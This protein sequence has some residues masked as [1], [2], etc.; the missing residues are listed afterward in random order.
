MKSSSNILDEIF[1]AQSGE[2]PAVTDTTK[3]FKSSKDVLDDIFSKSA[4]PV[5][6]TVAPKVEEPQFKQPGPV[7]AFG[8]DSIYA[9]PGEGGAEEH[10]LYVPSEEKTYGPISPFG[11]DSIYAMPDEGGSEMPGLH[12]DRIVPIEHEETPGEMRRERIRGVQKKIRSTAATVHPDTLVKMDDVSNILGDSL[13]KFEKVEKQLEVYIDKAQGVTSESKGFKEFTK[14][15]KS[16]IEDYDNKAV[17]H[18]LILGEL[19]DL[20][21]GLS[22]DMK[23]YGELVGELREEY[24][25]GFE[26]STADKQGFMKRL[27]NRAGLMI[28]GKEVRAAESVKQMVIADSLGVNPGEL[29]KSWGQ[30]IKSG[31]YDSLAGKITRYH[32]GRF[33]EKIPEDIMAE[34]STP[35]KLGA[36][37]SD[38]GV[39]LPYMAVGG[40]IASAGAPAEAAALALAGAF[41]MP[42]GLRALY[43]YLEEHGDVQDLNEFMEAAKASVWGTVKG[44]GVGLATYGAARAGAP[45]GKIPG[46]FTEVGGMVTSQAFVE[47]R[48]PTQDDFVQGILVISL[49]KLGMSPLKT[50]AEVINGSKNL[51]T[52]FV[53]TGIGPE[54]IHKAVADNMI[55]LVTKEIFKKKPSEASIA[56]AGKLAADMEQTQIKL[57]AARQEKIDAKKLIKAELAEKG[58]KV[59]AAKVEEPTLSPYEEGWKKPE[60]D[61]R[62]QEGSDG[63]IL[64]KVKKVKTKKVAPDEKQPD[65]YETPEETGKIEAE[66][67]T[68]KKFSSGIA[69]AIEEA[70][71]TIGLTKLKTSLKEIGVDVS[72]RAKL[73]AQVEEAGFN[74]VEKGRQVR[75]FDKKG[76]ETKK[77]TDLD[78]MTGSA[79]PKGLQ[80]G[81]HPLRETKLSQTKALK[82][83]FEKDPKKITESAEVFSRYLINE[84]NHY[85]NGGE[86]DIAKVRETLSTLAAK[87]GE[88]RAEFASD[89]KFKEWADLV[90][91]AAE[92]AR[93][94][95]RVFSKRSGGVQ[96]NMMIPLDDIPKMVKE[97]IKDF[98]SDFADF[99]EVPSKETFRNSKIYN[100]TGFWRARDGKWRYELDPSKIKLLF[101]QPTAD[102]YT[103]TMKPDKLYDITEII[104]APE[105]FK[106]VPGI[107]DLSVKFDFNMN[108][109]GTY[110]ADRELI[111][112]KDWGRNTFFHEL[113]HSINEYTGSKFKGTSVRQKEKE[114]MQDIVFRL[115]EV[116]EDPGVR[117]MTTQMAAD[118]MRG[119]IPPGTAREIFGLFVRKAKGTVDEAK[120]AEEIFNWIKEES[121]T[122]SYL[123]DPGEMEA[124]L[125]SKRLEM[126]EELGRRPNEPPWNTLDRMLRDE[127]MSEE[128]GTTLYSGV[129]VSK[130][131]P[132]IM[133]AANGIK[134]Y[135]KDARSVKSFKP[136]EAAG[137]IRR[138]LDLAIVDKSGGIRRDLLHTFSNEGYRILQKM[139][140]SAGSYARAADML[141]QMGREVYKG[142]SRHEKEILDNLIF[143]A[144]MVD[145]GKYKTKKEFKFPKGGEPI[146]AVAYK[147]LFE[148]VEG[149]S[150]KQ[151]AKIVKRADNYYEWMKKPLAEMLEAG[152]ISDIEYGDLIKHNYRKLKLVDNYDK[153]GTSKT[154][155]TK[156]NVY[157]SGIDKLARGRD[158]DIFEPSSEVMA[159]EVFNRAYG[160]IMNNEANLTLLELARNHK[161]NPFVAVKEGKEKVPSGWQRIHAYEVG[162]RVPIYLSPDMAR[163]WIV[164]NPEVTYKMAQ[165]L[166]YGSGAPI[167]RTFATGI[168]WGFALANLPRDVMH[169][170]FA[171]RT[172]KDG[173]WNRIYNPTAPVFG[174]EMT[175]D[176]LSVFRDALTRGPRYR[177]YIKQGGGM[178]L[179]T[180]QG[181]I[182][183][184]GKHLR[185]PA[186]PI[187][188]V[189]GY[190]GET[191]E[192]MTR[193]AIRDRVVRNLANERGISFK[194]AMRN[195]DITTE[196]SFVARDYMD[197]GQGG[198]VAKAFDNGVPYLN[199]SI[200]G[201]RGL[202]RSFKDSPIQ[203]VYMLTQFAALTTGMYISNQKRCP[204]TMASLKGDMSTQNNLIIPLSD[205]LGFTDSEGQKRY[206]VAKI[207]LDHGQRFFKKLFEACT[208]KWLGNEVDIEELVSTLKNLSPVDT[209]SLPPMLS[210][211]LG[212]IYNIDFWR[213]ES[214]WRRTEPMGWPDSQNERTGDTPE[215]WG[216][217]GD[218]TKLSPERAKQA[219]EELTT[220]GTVWSWS[221]GLGYDKLFSDVPQSQ[222]E[223]HLAEVLSRI[224][225]AKR[226]FSTTNPY[227]K[228]AKGVE[229]SRDKDEQKRFI[230][231][232]KLDTILDSYLIDKT[233]TSSDIFDYIKGM[234]EKD[235]RDR[236]IER[237]KFAIKTKNLP[238]R[239]YWMSLQGIASLKGRAENFAKNWINAT[240]Q[241]RDELRT[242]MAVVKKAGGIISSEFMR[243]VR[244]QIVIL[245]KANQSDE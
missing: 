2:Q 18:N 44:G 5:E 240:D 82:E 115:H 76:I 1:A 232:S 39:T 91:E 141:G 111:V 94:S 100:E 34:L 15:F 40:A 71:G 102:G 183:K 60:A 202:L 134:K 112:M 233:A 235:V 213:N 198:G 121:A 98:K 23:E 120:F 47:G 155:A 150:S 151:A 243:E 30:V 192:L 157:D 35:K 217:V 29:G 163:E 212:Y 174:L 172:F 110:F 99:M 117:K 122:D 130:V 221:A 7:P 133:E 189:L 196:A 181:R 124:R 138:E 149:I 13:K 75:I 85:L 147:E 222:R 201:T 46:F 58:K 11:K 144:R 79:K 204:E 36:M 164:S 190:F 137:M 152:L 67:E 22:P 42:G 106:A 195:K 118:A 84:V 154:G 224:P 24:I 231:N 219:I 61:I 45:A 165:V 86:I 139:Y 244:K 89:I 173:K 21:A 229:E 78:E 128:A 170:W 38:V 66:L 81:E 197:F 50:S 182:M 119:E 59:K 37:V 27:F 167:L 200:Q 62:D 203:S 176:Q 12:A 41:A 90:S 146:N 9:M 95:D 4:K 236:L 207:P 193:L 239:S 80:P 77:V 166:K 226:F 225:V 175:F 136:K 83:M 191:S 205:N 48:W 178:E 43:S 209:S 206:M 153:R 194:A 148:Y 3:K 87:A 242:G 245:R 88:D 125:A 49:L 101:E 234:K 216:D 171:A 143:A 8:Q 210:A 238:N 185:G 179:L 32:G 10:P 28:K 123:K 215:F 220:N 63:S 184:R 64:D 26:I 168:N 92:W 108:A 103:V 228:F 31:A 33:G 214:T 142:L 6:P 116:S 52:Y 25:K 132:L 104:D 97:L 54:G 55:P 180:L 177:E 93:N 131:A 68:S 188:N 19:N 109:R 72:D 127:G 208:D 74:Y 169:A 16:V 162:E 20:I 65:E 160:R 56:E 113:Q 211:V 126:Y 57:V 17:A 237:Y 218:M 140:L 129:D 14:N 156:R 70:G 53:E 227:T 107:K 69:M 96:L 145:I 114:L 159:L 158:S 223:Q 241:G 187:L 230:E 135:M 51:R 73:L 161:K 186:D 199:A 105:L